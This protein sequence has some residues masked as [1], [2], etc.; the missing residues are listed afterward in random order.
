MK[1]EN[2][3]DTLHKLLASYDDAIKRGAAGEAVAAKNLID[4]L[5]AK[6][7]V[8]PDSLR[9]PIRRQYLFKW[10]DTND[11]LLVQCCYWK[12]RDDWNAPVWG[13]KT[14]KKWLYFELTQAEAIDVE[15]LIRFYR[16]AFKEETKEFMT[17][18]VIRHDIRASELKQ[19]NEPTPEQLE[20]AERRASMG[21][22]MKHRG[23]P[24]VKGYLT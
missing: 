11:Q 1:A 3:R 20:A 13:S 7:K 10:R 14:N 12:V 24:L 5:A 18:F 6:Y 15:V 8:D 4:K 19:N 2:V 23:N 22:G 21:A 16:K 17:A 9:S